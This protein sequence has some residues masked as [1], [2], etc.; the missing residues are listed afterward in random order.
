[1]YLLYPLDM[2]SSVML[3]V[4]KFH[5]GIYT[6]SNCTDPKWTG[7]GKKSYSLF[8]TKE[9]WLDLCEL[10]SYTP[11]PLLLTRLL[12]NWQLTSKPLSSPAPSVQW[13][14]F[15]QSLDLIT[16]GVALFYIRLLKMFSVYIIRV[17]ISKAGEGLGQWNMSKR[18]Q[19]AEVSSGGAIGDLPWIHT[20]GHW[21]I[22]S[23]SWQWDVEGGW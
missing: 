23:F 19:G 3:S 14:P 16:W 21:L 1:M 5:S 2:S 18:Q 12:Y 10:D 11:L 4:F 22:P 20:R 9:K 8:S 7:L 17:A 6:K 15:K 13:W